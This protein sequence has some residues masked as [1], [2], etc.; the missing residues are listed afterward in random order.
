MAKKE[1]EDGTVFYGG[2]GALGEVG[3]HGVAG[4]SAVGENLLAGGVKGGSG[5]GTYTKTRFEL[6]FTQEASSLPKSRQSLTFFF[7]ARTD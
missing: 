7:N 1:A 2:V 6:S 4:V 5:V 3:E